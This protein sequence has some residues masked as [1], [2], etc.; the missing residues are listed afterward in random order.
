MREELVKQ[1]LKRRDGK[2]VLQKDKLAEFKELGAD[3]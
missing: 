3:L 2:T 1:G